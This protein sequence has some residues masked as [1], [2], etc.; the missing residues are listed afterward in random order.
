M[1][2][3]LITGGS[4][5]VGRH[6][7][8]HLAR[9]GYDVHVTVRR[10]SESAVCPEHVWHGADPGEFTE[11][12]AR[13]QPKI[14]IHLIAEARPTRTVDDMGAQFHNTVAPSLTVVRALPPSMELAVFI[15]SCEEYGDG[16]V[17]HDEEQTLR[18]ISP[19]GWAKISAYYGTTMAATLRGVPWCW[20]RPYLA[21]GPG[22]R[23]D[24]LIPYVISQCVSDHEA[25]ISP[26]K[27]TRD[28]LYI[29]DLCEM[30]RRL[31]AQPDRAVGQVVNLAS[32][33]PRP[34]REVAEMIHRIV[35]RGRLSIGQMAY[36]SSEAM[37]FYGCTKKFTRLFGE[38]ECRPF[39]ESLEKTIESYIHA[40]AR[41]QQA[42][43]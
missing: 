14:C 41:H 43:A 35:G 26:G 30:M 20:A 2:P 8:R 18:A 33:T 22:Q 38:F 16:P 3:L 12:V 15:G 34:I 39:K 29:D 7:S 10:L 28:F 5:F 6:L 42:R 37:D 24:R 11:I 4:G 32:G 23:S 25:V 17:P 9:S 1:K 19:Y 13:V 40:A 27:Q 36:R 31:I 21:F